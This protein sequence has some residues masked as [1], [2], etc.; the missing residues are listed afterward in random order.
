[1]LIKNT[2]EKKHTTPVIK[3]NS[4]TETKY[5]IISTLLKLYIFTENKTKMK[6]TEIVP[7]GSSS[8]DYGFFFSDF[9]FHI[10]P[11]FYIGLYFFNSGKEQYIN[12]P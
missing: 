6:C 1:M 7:L 8:E 9:I 4:K 12:Q 5:S 3:I 10:F 11:I 2:Q